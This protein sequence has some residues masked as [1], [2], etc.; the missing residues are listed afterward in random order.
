MRTRRVGPFEVSEIGLGCM[1]LSHA[2]G[3]KPAEDYSVKLLRR[4]L[5]LG[6][7]FFD[8]AALYG[9][10]HNESLV[11]EALS[12]RRQDFMLASKCG[13][14]RNA[15]GQRE[16]NGRPESLKHTCE[17]S[18][19]RL[20]TDVIDLYYLHRWDKAVAIE[21]SVGALADLVQAGKIRSIGLSEVSAAILRRAHAVH[22][23]A[24][25]QSEYSLWTRN[26][27]IAV[28]DACRELGTSFVAFSPVGRGFLA[29]G[30]RDVEAL[31]SSDMRRSMPRFQ[32]ENLAAN[33]RLLAGLDDIARETG[34]TVAQLSIAWVLAQ[35]EI[36]TPIPGTA[37]IAH[38]EEDFAAADL[39]L[40]AGLLAR[41]DG[42]I[43]ATT[44]AGGRYGEAT[45]R[46][47]DTE[48]A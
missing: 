7:T 4:A 36:V 30:V 47:V 19:R 46:E 44:V 23:I 43:N 12:G 2:Y 9:F 11:G 1:S 25:V 45:Q 26:P 28:L 34:A 29:G 40:D 3:V 38:M 18:L 37:S 10:G 17:E 35:D 8:T 22:P 39:K 41:L 14:I 48:D 20:K 33:L 15:E 16:I 6:C 21:E 32:G 31:A 24:A 42:L 5:D 27:E 13:I